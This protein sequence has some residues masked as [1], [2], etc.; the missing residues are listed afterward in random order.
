MLGE[1][2]TSPEAANEVGDPTTPWPAQ[3]TTRSEQV[4]KDRDFAPRE[5][6]PGV[7]RRKRPGARVGVRSRKVASTNPRRGAG[8]AA[9]AAFGSPTGGS[10]VEIGVHVDVQRAVERACLLVDANFRRCDAAT[11]ASVDDPPAVAVL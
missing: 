4:R 5:Q 2:K 11:A 6:V 3:R 8:V 10:K 7:I 1:W 9:Q